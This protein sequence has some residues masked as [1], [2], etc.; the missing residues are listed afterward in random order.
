MAA[1][2]LLCSR[3]MPS[4]YCPSAMVVGTAM[5]ANYH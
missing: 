2:Y 5:P 4:L 3:L 1:R